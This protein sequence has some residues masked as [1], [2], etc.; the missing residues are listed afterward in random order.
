ML[1]EPLTNDVEGLVLTKMTSQSSSVAFFDQGFFSGFMRD[2]KLVAFQKETF[3]DV[4]VLFTNMIRVVA[5]YF[6]KI[7]KILLQI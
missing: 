6:F 5:P 2:I 4:E 7:F 3:N 1:K